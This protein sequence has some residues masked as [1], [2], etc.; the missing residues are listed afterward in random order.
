MGAEERE[1]IAEPAISGNSEDKMMKTIVIIRRKVILWILG[2]PVVVSF[3]YR[4]LVVSVCVYV[5]A[6][7]PQ[8]GSGHKF[9]EQIRE[10]VHSWAIGVCDCNSPKETIHRT[11]IFWM[12]AGS[13]LPFWIT[14]SIS[15]PPFFD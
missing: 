12:G 13:G 11:C 1:T 6:V 9:V 4:A 7:Y 8:N 10:D 15:N 3:V 2:G 5:C 14:V